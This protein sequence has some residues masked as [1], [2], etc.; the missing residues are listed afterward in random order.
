M[1]ISKIATSKV[2]KIYTDRDYRK[3]INIENPEP[4]FIGMYINLITAQQSDKTEKLQMIKDFF[5]YT[6]RDINLGDNYRIHIK[7][8]VLRPNKDM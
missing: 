8:K 1:G 2:Y 4:E 6:T 5:R 7:S 3:S